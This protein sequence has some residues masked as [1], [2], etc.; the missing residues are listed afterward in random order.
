[1]NLRRLIGSLTPPVRRELLC[2]RCGQRFTCEA[3][4][5]GCWCE[6][7]KLSKAASAEL[8]RRYGDCLCRPCLESFAEAKD[9]GLPS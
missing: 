2:E 9:P 5:A 6:E 1:M 3:S 4:L 7:I 8:R